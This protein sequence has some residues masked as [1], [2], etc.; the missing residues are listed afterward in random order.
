MIKISGTAK[1][2][3]NY[4]VKLK[5]TRESFDALSEKSQ[6]ALIDNTVDWIDACRV[7]EIDYIEIDALEE[8]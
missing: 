6:N 1:V 2:I 8:V 3:V 4:E 7:A 5:M